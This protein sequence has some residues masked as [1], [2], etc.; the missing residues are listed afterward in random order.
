MEKLDNDYKKRIYLSYNLLHSD[1][2]FFLKKYI[3]NKTLGIP[4][5]CSIVNTNGIAFK[6][7]FKN[8]WRFKSNNI[9]ERVSGNVG[10]HFISFLENLFG[11]IKKIDILEQKIA[12]NLS[13]DTCNISIH[14]VNKFIANIFLSYATIQNENLK[15]NFSNGLLIFDGKKIFSH[16]PRNTF[17]KKGYFI[18]PKKRIIKNFREYW[19]ISSLEKSVNFFVKSVQEKKYFNI[20]NFNQSLRNILLFI[21][22]VEKN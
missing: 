11:K 22:S 5:S 13:E 9:F 12:T 10:I 3:K 17:D 2:Y 6:K 18:K 15:I 16:S 4:I 19:Y 8:D 20:K 1:L 7:S 14:F 21:Q